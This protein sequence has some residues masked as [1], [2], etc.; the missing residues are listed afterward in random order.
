MKVLYVD[1]E[2]PA[3]ENFKFTVAKFEDVKELTTFQSGKEALEFAKKNKVDVAFLDME[4]PEMHGLELAKAL[5]EINT[6][7]LV[8]FVTAFSQY[9]LE[10]FSV[11]AIG[12]VM[13]PYTSTEIRKELD[14]VAARLSEQEK[15]SKS[16]K[17]GKKRVEIQTIP[18]FVLKVDG[19][20][21]TL[22][23]PKAEELLALLVDRGDAGLTT[24]EAIAY[25]WPDR[26]MDSN[27]S[28]L[29]RNTAKRMLDFLRDHEISELVCTD[30]RKRYID[31]SLVDCDLYKILAGS[32]KELRKYDGLYMSRWSWSE[33][34]N[35]W[36]EDQKY[37]ME[38]DF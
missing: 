15:N 18:D 26:P 11:N 4:M 5:Q 12:Y 9:A 20:V 23:R 13:K 24:G 38:D 8:V 3:L 21:V 25:L 35:A 29:F 37:D 16:S 19:H 32:K 6:K 1:D 27:T 10:A 22:N 2:R 28:S 30:G 33:E 14:K 17:A 7:M 34:R 36:L 31:T